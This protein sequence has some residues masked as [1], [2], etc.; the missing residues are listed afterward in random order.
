M[1]MYNFV[2]GMILININIVLDLDKYY[3]WNDV[4]LM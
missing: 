2:T 1:Y 3:S 4:I